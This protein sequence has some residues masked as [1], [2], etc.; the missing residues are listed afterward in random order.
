MQGCLGLHSIELILGFQLQ[1]LSK[2]TA[3]EFS[4]L[5]SWREK[6]KQTTREARNKILMLLPEFLENGLF[7]FFFAVVCD[8]GH[9]GHEHEWF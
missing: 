7:L 6:N 9:R 5:V 3:L 2:S 1:N 4:Q 8:S